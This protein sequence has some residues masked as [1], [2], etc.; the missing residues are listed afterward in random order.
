MSWNKHKHISAKNQSNQIFLESSHISE[1][2]F[3]YKFENRNK[4]LDYAGKRLRLF[5][6]WRKLFLKLF[7]C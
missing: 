5:L 1:D 6:W 2:T 7:L 4:W 3:S